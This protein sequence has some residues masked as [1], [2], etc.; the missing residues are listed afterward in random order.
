MSTHT[1]THT[2]ILEYLVGLQHLRQGGVGDCWFLSALAVVAERHDLIAKLFKDTASNA[3]G[4]YNIRL[5]L[6]GQW[7]PILIDDMLPCTKDP[8]RPEHVFDSVRL[9]FL[10]SRL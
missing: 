4:C 8:R 5:F 3:A 9:F 2:L 7:Q 1:H 10:F 6:D